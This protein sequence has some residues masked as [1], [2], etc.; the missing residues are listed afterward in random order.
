MTQKG[1]NTGLLALSFYLYATYV[2]LVDEPFFIG[3]AYTK[4]KPFE[5][6]YIEYG[7]ETLSALLF[8]LAV[9]F[10][11]WSYKESKS[12]SDMEEDGESIFETLYLILG[13]LVIS[14]Y[15]VS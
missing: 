15:M 13:I 3:T 14:V 1:I 6:V 2:L 7:P 11:K 10:T 9:I 4:H 12:K 8:L 5:W